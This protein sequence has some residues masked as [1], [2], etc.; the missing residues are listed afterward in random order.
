MACEFICDGCGQRAA[1]S[2][3]SINWFKPSTWFERSDKDG[4]GLAG[5]QRTHTKAWV[6]ANGAVPEGKELDHTCRRRNCRALHH[7]ELVTRSENELRK[8]WRY[9]ARRKTCSKGHDLQIHRAVTPEG[10]VTCRTCNREAK[11]QT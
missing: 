4:Y 2:H 3:N 7:L 9:R 11:G 8:S 6:E 5:R 10:G 1:A